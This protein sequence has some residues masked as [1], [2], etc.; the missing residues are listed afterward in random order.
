MVTANVARLVVATVF[1]FE[2]QM[3]SNSEIIQ[4]Q[5]DLN[6]PRTYPMQGVVDMVDY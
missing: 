3:L 6:C 5:L 4:T 2:F 1:L